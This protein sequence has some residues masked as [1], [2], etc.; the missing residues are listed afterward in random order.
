MQ[1][2]C[3]I[4]LLKRPVH[5]YA[6]LFKNQIDVYSNFKQKYIASEYHRQSYTKK[7]TKIIFSY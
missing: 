6:I 2:D 5:T 4:Y 3:P 7:S 1:Y